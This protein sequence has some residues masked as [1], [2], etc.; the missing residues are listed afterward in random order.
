MSTR[1]KNNYRV[2]PTPDNTISY[3]SGSI[4]LDPYQNRTSV[5]QADIPAGATVVLEAR[6]DASLPF[7]TVLTASDSDVLQEVVTAAEYRINVTNVTGNPV[8]AAMTI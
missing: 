2:F 6:I 5:F 7:V 1:N 4:K 3:V 8:I